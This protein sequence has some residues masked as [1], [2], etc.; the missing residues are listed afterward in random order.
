VLLLFL[1]KS[2]N[3]SLIAGNSTKE[4]FRRTL[5]P[6]RRG[7]S[8]NRLEKS[9]DRITSEIHKQTQAGGG[10]QGEEGVCKNWEEG[11]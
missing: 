10:G 3:L 1:T 9:K 7:E 2:N 4:P 8:G 5:G 11:Q 6:I